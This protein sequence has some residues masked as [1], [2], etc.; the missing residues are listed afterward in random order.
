MRVRRLRLLGAAG[1]GVIA[2]A[3][4]VGLFAYGPMAAWV[5]RSRVVP[6]VSSRLGT[7]MSIGEMDIGRGDATLR[8]VVF[9]AVD[10]NE[11]LATIARI[12][13]TFDFWSSLVGRP[14]VIDLVVHDPDVHLRR[15]D[16]RVDEVLRHLQGQGGQGAKTGNSASLRPARIAVR[17]GKMTLE[18]PETGSVLTTGA[19]TAELKKGQPAALSIA[20]V[21]LRSPLAPKAGA[22]AVVLRAEAS[23]P[24]ATASIEVHGGQLELWP[25]MTL[26]GIVGSAGHGES[27]GDVVI[28][29]QGSYGGMTETLWNAKGSVNPRTRT[30]AIDVVAKELELA[31]LAPVLEGTGIIE[32]EHTKLGAS[33]HVEVNTD[34][35][36]VSGTGNVEHLNVFRPRIA[37]KPIRDVSATAE[38]RG[39]VIAS[40]RML[41]LERADVTLGGVSYHL[42][43]E[44][45][46]ADPAAAPDDRAAKPRFLARLVVPE[47]PCQ[48]MLESLPADFVP[49]LQGFE[50]KGTFQTDI[51]VGVDWAD[52]D[53]STLEG[54][55]GIR[56]C[57]VV[58]APEELDADRL[59]EPFEHWVEVEDGQWVSFVVGPDNPDYVAIDDISKHLVNSIMTTEDS[60]FYKH[61]GFIPSEMKS[62][63][64]KDLKAGYF[65]YG[66]SS[67]TMQMVKNVIL[68]R[69]KTLARKFQ[70]LFFT[71]YLESELEKDRILEIYLN[72]IEYGPGLYGI[73]PATQEY[74]GKHPREL[75]PVEA[76]FFSSILP[77]PKKRYAQY[78]DGQLTGWTKGKIQRILQLMKKR[79]RLDES[80][81]MLAAVTPLEFVIRD[82]VAPAECKKR[83][84]R[85][86]AQKGA[87]TENPRKR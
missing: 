60:R 76:A 18:D 56:N 28:D 44:L 78:C 46:L 64:I 79:E 74:F 63:M 4:V 53:A 83:V 57:K 8:N 71:W 21:R 23:D 62:A 58:R 2:L 20:D 14:R 38:L 84:E 72:V 61:K 32:P 19:V 26:T 29:F 65:K 5:V 42:E 77:N 81:Y 55:V 13:V 87:A 7:T 17:G 80:E 43:G 69:E 3:L 9:G 48:T 41:E 59:K 24:L 39:A 86:L 22:A 51:S 54:S 40:K 12:D 37:E 67:I 27:D 6:K 31:R 25:G 68:Y 16:P 82:E 36:T 49:Y 75:S 73:G 52:L 30:G 15:G 1:L 33:L 66:A 70:E 45:Q 85:F 47:V 50:L 34:G 11:P 35:A 10:G